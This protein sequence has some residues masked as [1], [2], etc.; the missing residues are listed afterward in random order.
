MAVIPSPGVYVCVGGGCLVP[1]SY[2]FPHYLIL[3]SLSSTS[4]NMCF[5][6]SSQRHLSITHIPV[7][8]PFSSSS[9]STLIYFIPQRSISRVHL[10][11]SHSNRP[12][13]SAFM[14]QV[15]LPY[16]DI[17]HFTRVTYTFRLNFNDAYI[18]PCQ[19]H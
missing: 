13:C 9:R 3:L 2:I 11:S 1:Y 18:L 16:I 12:I 5:F 10:I 8:S 15:S 4:Y 19:D 17:A 6:S 14:T 7:Q